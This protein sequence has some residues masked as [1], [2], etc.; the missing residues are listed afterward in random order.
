MRPAL[1]TFS[2]YGPPALASLHR[3]FLPRRLARL[4]SR[5]LLVGCTRAMSPD[6]LKEQTGKHEN[7]N[8]SESEGEGAPGSRSFFGA[9][10]GFW[11]ATLSCLS[12]AAVSLEG[13]LDRRHGID[14]NR[15]LRSNERTTYAPPSSGVLRYDFAHIASNEPAE[16]EHQEAVV[17]VLPGHWSFFGIY[18]G[19]N[20]GD[21]SKW[22]AN[23][24]IAAVTGALADLYARLV[25]RPPAAAS[26]V[27]SPST[28]DIAW[29]LKETFKQLD[30]DIVHGP[31]PAALAAQA[32][33]QGLTLLAPA[34]AGSCALL[35]FYDSHARRL[36]VALTGDSR[37]VL[38]RRRGLDDGEGGG[39]GEETRYD[40]YILCTEQNGSN[41]DEVARVQGEH[42]GETVVQNGRF[43]GMAVSRAF[44][45][46]RLKWPR[47]VQEKLKRRYRGRAP[48]ADVKT[49]PYITAE[50]EVTSV[51]VEPGDF[52]ILATDGIW[53]SITSEEAV[54]LVGLWKEGA[55][56]G[57]FGKREPWG[58][59]KRFLRA[60][61]NAATHLIRNALG[62]ADKDLTA[63]LLSMRTP[64]ARTYRDDM[65]AVVVFFSDDGVDDLPRPKPDPRP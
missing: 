10:A 56:D 25:P 63:S 21:T 23:N 52:L 13:D 40:V 64:K 6:K 17:P 24:L 30:D 19:H 35:A 62:G 14:I 42:P 65:T 2:K 28:H 57:G 37:A 61:T 60:D 59:D 43:F 12:N 18:D 50:P 9:L 41:T 34:W 3:P 29:T 55:K 22:L 8:K 4:S 31:L 36:H 7:E 27:P 38:G 51:E 5:G 11:T 1:P 44:G 15:V 26:P 53:E 54:G 46:A 49:P 47:D 45:D 33:E 16:D 32:R 48:L 39:E 58:A 20:G